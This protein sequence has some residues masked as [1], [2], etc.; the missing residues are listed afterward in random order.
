MGCAPA[1]CWL[2]HRS[3]E[4]RYDVARFLP[5]FAKLPLRGVECKLCRHVV[6][7]L[8]VSNS[9]SLCFAALQS[10]HCDLNSLLECLTVFLINRADPRHTSSPEPDTALRPNLRSHLR[11][12]CCLPRAQTPRGHSDNSQAQ[13][14]IQASRRCHE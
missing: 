11:A 12:R 9:L 14:S 1:L 8:Q 13:T 2:R 7:S 10:F 5:L 6:E 3:R 4:Q